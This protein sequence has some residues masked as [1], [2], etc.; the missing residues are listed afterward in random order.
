MFSSVGSGGK[1]S[2]RN[3]Q[4]MLIFEPGLKGVRAIRWIHVPTLCHS[5]E[6]NCTST[7]T[8][9]S[10]KKIRPKKFV[11]SICSFFPW[12]MIVSMMVSQRRLVT[13]S[14]ISPEFRNSSSFTLS[15][16]L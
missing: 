8:V 11:F 4:L 9:Y 7:T 6:Q 14:I 10:D 1:S 13:V 3:D 12:A 16:S 15:S 2:S 5:S